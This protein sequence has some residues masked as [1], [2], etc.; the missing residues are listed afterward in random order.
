MGKEIVEI[1]AEIIKQ[2]DF[3]ILIDDGEVRVWLPKNQIE[4][5]DRVYENCAEISIPEWLAEEKELI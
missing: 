5:I 2:T 4:Q 3:A 1:T